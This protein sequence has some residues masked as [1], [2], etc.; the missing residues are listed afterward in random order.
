[1]CKSV[2]VDLNLKRLI[3]NHNDIICISLACM[4]A[5]R[6]AGRNILLLYYIKP[7]KTSECEIKQ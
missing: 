4:T 3:E 1:M 5:T 2:A 7:N 6:R